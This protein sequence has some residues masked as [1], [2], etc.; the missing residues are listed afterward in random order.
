M[1]PR[2]RTV[3][4]TAAGAS[5]L[6]M[7]VCCALCGMQLGNNYVFL[8]ACLAGG[9]VVASLAI[10]RN[11][12]RGIDARRRLPFHIFAGTTV[13][14]TILLENRRA[15]LP[16]VQLLVHDT[17]T[18]EP[19][20]GEQPVSA[21]PYV[22][23]G[24]RLESKQAVRFF[25]RGRAAFATITITSTFP[26][27]LFR[28]SRSVP[29]PEGVVVYPRLRPIPASLLPPE[30]GFARAEALLVSG[31]RGEDE[32]AGL[33][34]FRPGDN[35]K[36]IHWKSSARL[37]DRRLVKELEGT[38]T[39]RVAVFFD[40]FLPDGNG[41]RGARFNRAVSLACSL[42]RELVA[43]SYQVDFTIF[44]PRQQKHQI[45]HHDKALFRLFHTMA[46]LEPTRQEEERVAVPGPRRYA[47]IPTLT[48]RPAALAPKKPITDTL[49]WQ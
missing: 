48:I 8:I 22:P 15:H 34:E 5:V 47:R 41:H 38:A 46:L 37:P 25:T 13:Y 42:V 45:A 14:S 9:I 44:G 27:G 20:A 23:A 40:T 35:P 18:S 6:F 2:P 30:T 33:R 24:S 21:V 7:T 17:I 3:R 4:L 26:F 1:N 29:L 43:R 16:A 28:A 19:V 36:L 49:R 12:L 32:F 39:R 11:N 31:P 10:A